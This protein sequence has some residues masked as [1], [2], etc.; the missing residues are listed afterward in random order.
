[1]YYVYTLAYPDGSIF[2]V[3]KGKNGRI[4][5]HEREVLNHHFPCN[6]LKATIIREILASGHEVLKTIVAEFESERD[7]YTYEWG[8]MC[9]HCMANQFTNLAY[10]HKPM[11]RR[12]RTKQERAARREYEINKWQLEIFRYKELMPD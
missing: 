6:L 5:D 10:A 1:M 3:G 7:A 4:N 8:L 11:P 12:R 9:M 2:Y